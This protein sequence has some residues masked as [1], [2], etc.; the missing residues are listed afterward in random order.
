MKNQLH[1]I[2]TKTAAVKFVIIG[3]AFHNAHEFSKQTYVDSISSVLRAIEHNAELLRGIERILNRQ[4]DDRLVV[5]NL[6]LV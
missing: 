3:L 2:A 1:K 6:L 4:N 5:N